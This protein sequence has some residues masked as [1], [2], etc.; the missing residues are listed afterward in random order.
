M[1]GSCFVD[2]NLLVYAR[3]ATEADKQ[4]RAAQWLGRLWEQRAGRLSY[5]V[6]QEYYVT[7]TAK[8]T[9]GLEPAEA[10]DDVRALM[11]WEPIA[12]SDRVIEAA[13]RVQDRF[14]FSWWDSLIVAAAQ[15]AGCRYLLSEDLHSEQDL[16]GM[17][18]LDPFRITPQQ[19]LGG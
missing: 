19:V 17:Q 18:V 4:P 1:S 12:V 8:L 6:L 14:R 11:T 2:T 10:R 16:D 15:H 13:W 7:V 3:D 5:Q 9:P